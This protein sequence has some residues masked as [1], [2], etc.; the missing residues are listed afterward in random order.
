MPNVPGSAIKTSVDASPCLERT[1]APVTAGVIAEASMTDDA[2]LSSA[3]EVKPHDGTAER[4]S[5]T[6]ALR[7]DLPF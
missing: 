3:L 2:R 5:R 7:L 4:G 1:S 6:S